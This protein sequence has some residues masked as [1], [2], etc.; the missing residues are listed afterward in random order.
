[1]HHTC[2]IAGAPVEEE[3]SEGPA[4]TIPFLGIEIDSM[5]MELRLPQ[6]KLTQLQRVLSQWRGKKVCLKRDLLSIIGSLSQACKVVKS[7]RAFVR[8]LIDLSKSAKR[9]H[10]HIR[11]SRE[12]RSDIEWWYQFAGTWN[13]VS[14]L[15]AQKQEQPH[16]VV[17]SD[18][19]GRWGCGAFFDQKWFQLQWASSMQDSNITIKELVP[20]VLAAA[21]WGKEWYG[22]TMQARCDNSAVVAILNWGNSQDP[23]VM[24]LI[25]CLAFIKAKFQ[26]CLFASH[27]QGI[28]TT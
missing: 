22:L 7:G 13:G 18:A 23:E 10:H 4:T 2:H 24:H 16:I 21:V 3:K 17:T 20:I 11:L 25:R 15:R 8:H 9:P 12:P 26:I 27:I 1:M 19:S 6:E 14:I 28:K 5:A